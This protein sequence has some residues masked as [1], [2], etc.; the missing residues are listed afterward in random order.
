MAAF[1][2]SRRVVIVV[3]AVAVVAVVAVGAVLFVNSRDSSTTAAGSGSSTAQIAIGD[4]NRDGIKDLG[5]AS[6]AARVLLLLG[7][8]DATFVQQPTITLLADTG[9]VDA[10]DI[11]IADFNGDTL[12]DLVVAIALNG[13]RTAIL[14]G[15]GD[16]TFRAPSI[17]TEPQIRIPQYQAVGDYNGDGFQD[18]AMSLGF[19]S[20]G[21]ME[22]RNGNGDGT[23][24][25]LVLYL[26]PPP[27]SSIG[28]IHIVSSDFN[29][30]GKPDIALNYG[31][32]S[33]GVVA[34][35]NTTGVAPAATLSSVTV[36][37]STVVGGT[38]STA[39]VTLS[40]AAP[41]GGAVVSLSD[42]SSIVTT[43]ASVIVPA[44]ATSGTATITT[45]P[46]T[47][48]TSAMVSA[49]FAGVT[50][51]AT[52][53]VTAPALPTPSAP[54]LVSPANGA[55]VTLPV[56]LD[57]S[58]VSAAASYQI[59]VD[60]SSTFSAP[61]VVEQTVAVSQFTAASLAIRQHWW[62]VRGVNSAG[63]A[64]AWSST[65]SFTPQG[66]AP[67]GGLATLTVTAAG[68][69]GER[70]TSSPTGIN[71][72]VGSTASAPFSTGTSITLSASGGRDA[73][74]SGACSSG[75]N[76]RRTCT[77]TITGTASVTANVQ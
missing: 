75:G 68:R 70:I 72:S 22:I 64:G 11:D 2:G 5:L 65:R 47:A 33:A 67:P 51:T 3:A 31:G 34:L 49:A 10:T 36:S 59:Q 69:S 66:A 61:R 52:L 60:D 27:L 6:S 29:N 71:V 30:D 53:T 44:G 32:A 50:R 23:F 12:Q 25:P 55:T 43:P 48:P 45:N 58:D 20:N 74:W 42:N 35:R 14:I 4:F 16:G 40:A 7:V 18:L 62:R 21:L 8:G 46:V 76:K 9:F 1:S 24:G 63:T 15:N 19:G 41:S 17:I 28:G 13:S 73:I 39:R 54:S 57:W 26:Q 56:T 37:P 38:S 77:F